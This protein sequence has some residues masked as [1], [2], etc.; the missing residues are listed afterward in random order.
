MCCNV[1][2]QGSAHALFISWVLL[3]LMTFCLLDYIINNSFDEVLC[4]FFFFLLLCFFEFIPLISVGNEMGEHL[5][6]DGL[7]QAVPFS[8]SCC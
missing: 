1:K 2:L 7:S 6:V 4:L 3:L 8:L 5:S